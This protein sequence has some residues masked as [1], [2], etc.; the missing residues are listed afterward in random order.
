MFPNYAQF[1]LLM[2]MKMLDHWPYALIRKLN[3]LDATQPHHLHIRLFLSTPANPTFCDYPII[4]LF[5]FLFSAHG[6]CL[7]RECSLRSLKSE[8]EVSS[9]YL[10]QLSNVYLLDLA[11]W[12]VQDRIISLRQEHD[13]ERSKEGHITSSQS[14]LELAATVRD[15]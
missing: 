10:F 15:T 3:G 13:K 8:V 4:F 2:S 7:S 12:Y 6:L 14:T 1:G 5:S 9:H 11:T